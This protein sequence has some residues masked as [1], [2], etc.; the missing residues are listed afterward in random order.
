MIPA[1]ERVGRNQ[2]RHRF[3]ALTAKRVGECREAAAFGVCKTEPSA[4]ELRFEDTVFLLEVGD[5]LLLVLLQ[6]AGHHG[7]EH[8]QDHRVFSG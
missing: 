7:D 5:D 8:V 2:R 4:T 1:Q 6:P 3:E